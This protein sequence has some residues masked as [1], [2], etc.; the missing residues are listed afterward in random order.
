[1]LA[2]PRHW[3][4]LE[5]PIL[6]VGI[7]DYIKTM[8]SLGIA[9][10]T[11]VGTQKDE[12]K[13]RYYFE[14]AAIGG[15]VQARHNLG[16]VEYEAGNVDRALRHYLIAVEDGFKKSLENTKVLFMEG[17]ATKPD[18][19]KALRLYQAYLDDIKSEQRDEAAA[20]KADWNYY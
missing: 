13:A 16:F 11:G 15:D 18:Y 10:M 2:M 12:K 1:M 7:V 3:A 14:L 20:F 4:I 8:P 6:L 9:Y 17:Y 19:A 5:M